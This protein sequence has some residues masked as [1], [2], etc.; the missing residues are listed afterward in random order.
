MVRNALILVVGAVLF[1]S[2]CST[3]PAIKSTTSTSSFNEWLDPARETTTTTEFY[4][5][6]TKKCLVDSYVRKDGTTVNSYYRSC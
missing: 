5:V 4:D 6:P 3:D 1:L 2:G